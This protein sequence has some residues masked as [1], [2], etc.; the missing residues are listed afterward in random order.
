LIR[1]D[2]DRIRPFVDDSKP[3]VAIT[4]CGQVAR[5]ELQ[6]KL[7]YL[8]DNNHNLN[9]V[10]IIV[11]N[12]GET[13]F[14]NYQNSQQSLAFNGT[15]HQLVDTFATSMQWPIIALKTENDEISAQTPLIAT[16]L[17]R[18]QS[19]V[20]DIWSLVSMVS[21]QFTKYAFATSIIEHVE[22]QLQR[23]FDYIVKLRDDDMLL[24]TFDL[25]YVI[26][27]LSST[28][29]DIAVIGC[30]FDVGG[31]NDHIRVLTRRALKT[32]SYDLLTN[33]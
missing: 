4:L 8:L 6:S 25:N 32:T 15:L 18:S 1:N 21:Q 29:G 17:F 10:L 24:S 19:W 20:N 5:T 12:D 2:I 7:N 3:L 11:M 27:Q 14:V 28:S 22:H 23:K 9:I 26:N 30:I 13:R 33:V 16:E 31:I